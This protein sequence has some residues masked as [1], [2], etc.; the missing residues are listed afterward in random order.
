MNSQV[1]FYA[2]NSK[3]VEQ[4]HDIPQHAQQVMYYSLAIGH[5]VGVIDCFQAVINCP[6]TQYKQWIDH[7]DDSSEAHAKLDRLFK[8]GEITVDISHVNLLANAFLPK[9]QSMEEPFRTWTETLFS[10]FEAMTKEPAMY[11][12]I[13]RIGQD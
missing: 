12:M 6:A 11:L 8:F 10:L 1:L 5:H 4:E 7:I 3:F 13:K 9:R 2:L